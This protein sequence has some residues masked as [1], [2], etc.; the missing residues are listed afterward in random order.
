MIAVL[1]CAGLFVQTIRTKTVSSRVSQN[2]KVRVTTSFYPLYFFTSQI[3][4]D[5]VDVTNITPSGAEPHDYEPT[6]QD[7]VKIEESDLLVLNGGVEAWGNKVQDAL[8]D[9]GIKIVTA[10]EGLL[11]QQITEDNQT[12]T[13]PHV[14]LSPELAKKEVDAISEALIEFAPQD[15]SYFEARTIALKGQLDQLDARYR[16]S[17]ATC[18]RKDIITSHAAFGYLATAYGLHQ[19]PIAGL[20]P[21]EE[22]SPKQLIGVVDF[23]KSHNATYIFFESL[24]SPKLS[25]TIASEVGAKTLVLDPLEGI[26]DA[27]IAQGKDYFSVMRDNLSNLQTALQCTK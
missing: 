3:G 24:V 8:K 11:T 4:G 16:Q 5:K 6:T 21:D 1:V 20:S 25:D 18:K 10:G 9:R 23:A 19:I 26:S 15:K 14:W 13:D 7:M 12:S 27:D 2:E 17:L 22:P